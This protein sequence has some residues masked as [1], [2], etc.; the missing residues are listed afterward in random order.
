LAATDAE[1]QNVTKQREL[2]AEQQGADVVQPFPFDLQ[3]TFNPPRTMDLLYFIKPEKLWLDMTRYKNFVCECSFRCLRHY[4]DPDVVTVQ[5]AVNDVK[6]VTGD[7]V[8]ITNDTAIE[9]QVG[10]VEDLKQ[11]G[12]WVA[13]ILEIRAS[14]HFHVYARIYWMYSPNDLPRKASGG[15]GMS[16]ARQHCC[17]QNELVASNHSQLAL[18]S[19]PSFRLMYS[20]DEILVDII[21]VVS[22]A[23]KANI[24]QEAEVDAH[25][26]GGGLY[27]RQ[28]FDYLTSQISVRPRTH[29]LRRNM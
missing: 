23:A 17:S 27:W 7:F 1:S 24:Y 15:D 28:A 22:V 2:V 12:Y 6:Y 4:A 13:K 20:A 26:V 3:G 16:R 9:Q 8:Y 19:L 11:L 10:G 5:P 14:D 21:N 18:P 25:K 29:Y